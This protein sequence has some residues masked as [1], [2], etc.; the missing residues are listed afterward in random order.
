MN[1][2]KLKSMN[3]LAQN[4]WLRGDNS[5]SIVR[6]FLFGWKWHRGTVFS[7][8]PESLLRDFAV[9]FAPGWWGVESAISLS[10]TYQLLCR[11]RNR[12][13]QREM[14]LQWRKRWKTSGIYSKKEEWIQA[15]IYFKSEHPDAEGLICW[16]V[17]NRETSRSPSNAHAEHELF[18]PTSTHLFIRCRSIIKSI[19]DIVVRPIADEKR[20][21]R[22]DKIKENDN[23][24]REA[25]SALVGC[26]T[27]TA[28][29]DCLA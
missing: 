10:L 11:V 20:K 18:T 22:T 1:E 13:L 5:N 15:G 19:L 27:A 25:E 3:T 29:I 26:S 8:N 2:G 23:L 17:S 7:I 6:W 16:Q 28:H 4:V 21:V 14:Q 9:M 24:H 12:P